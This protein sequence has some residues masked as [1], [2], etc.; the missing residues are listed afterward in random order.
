MRSKEKSIQKI[1]LEMRHIGLEKVVTMSSKNTINAHDIEIT[2][3]D[4][5]VT[6]TGARNL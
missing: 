1:I 5:K 4:F 3:I 2:G 6:T